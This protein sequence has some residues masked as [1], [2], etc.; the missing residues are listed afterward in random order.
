M[1]RFEGF[2]F[3]IDGTAIPDGAMTVESE[4]LRESFDALPDHVYAIAATGR[5]AKFA[6]P[7]L[8]ELALRH[9]AVVANGA[10]CIDPQTGMQRWEQCMT[11]DQV[12]IMLDILA[13][14]SYQLAFEDDPMDGYFLPIEQSVRKTI[15]AFLLNLPSET[16]A[17]AH[18]E[19]SSIPDV[20][21]YVSRGWDGNQTVYDV[22]IGHA[23]SRKDHALTRVL[24]SYAIKPSRMVAI[25]DGA[26]DIDL[27]RMAGYKVAVANAVPELLA[28][29]DEIVPSQEDGGL[30]V[31]VNRFRA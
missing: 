17:Q 13:P 19:I 21:A 27:F 14:Y 28:L 2:I 20:Y 12:A 22:N 26:N 9:D 30:V 16:A 18:H 25:G 4:E 15:G 5:T 6:M 29:A 8:G 23:N 1:Q 24:N 11:T 31:V 7:I 3:D 10:A